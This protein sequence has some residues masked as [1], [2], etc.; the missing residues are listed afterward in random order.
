MIELVTKNVLNCE[1]FVGFIFLITEY[2][3]KTCLISELKGAAQM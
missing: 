1:I 2:S 3:D